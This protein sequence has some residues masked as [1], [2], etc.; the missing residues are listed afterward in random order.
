MD[1]EMWPVYALKD[2]KGVKSACVLPVRAALHVA[3][4]PAMEQQTRWCFI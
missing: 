1:F 3:G 4:R 2:F